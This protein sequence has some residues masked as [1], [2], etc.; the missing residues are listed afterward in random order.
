M[1]KDRLIVDA[2]KKSGV[3]RIAVVDD[4]FD[5]PP[6]PPASDLGEVL[7][8]FERPDAAE[9]F[10]LAGLAGSVLARAVSA[11][12]KGDEDDD[13]LH[14]CWEGLYSAFLKGF[15]VKF[16]PAGRFGII[17]GDNLA[18][19]RPLLKLLRTCG[20]GIRIDEIGSDGR[21]LDN[22][23]HD[24]HLIFADFILDGRI[25]PSD[26]ARDDG[27][28]GLGRRIAL[29]KVRDIVRKA[30]PGRAPSVVLMSSHENLR[31]EASRFREGIGEGD[32]GKVFNSRFCFIAK[33]QLQEGS[34][35]PVLVDS[36]AANDLL[37]VFASYEFGQGLQ[38]ALDRWLNGAAAAVD[39]L[40]SDIERLD[41]RDFAYLVR[42]R[43]AQ[44]GQG[45]LDYLEWF[46]GECLLDGVS[47][48]VDA[49]GTP[50]DA[51][52]MDAKAAERLQGVFAGPTGEV[53][54]LFHRVRIEDH[55]PGRR[56]EYRLGDIYERPIEGTK[57]TVAAVLTPDCDLIRRKNGKRAAKS[58]LTVRGK[59]SPLRDP[60]KEGS[61]SDF[62]QIGGESYNIAW[63]KKELVS[64]DP[65]GWPGLGAGEGGP[66]YL[67]T[68]RPLYAQQLQR[69]VLHDLGRVGVSVAP[70]IAM[71]ANV[72]VRLRAKGGKLIDVPIGGTMSGLCHVFPGR[73]GQDRTRVLFDRRYV[74][75]LMGALSGEKEALALSGQVF[76]QPAFET[77]VAELRGD[78]AFDA[79]VA[80]LCHDG[81]ELEMEVAHGFFVTTKDA[82]GSAQGK[83]AW[84]LLVIAG[85]R[86]DTE[87]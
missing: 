78:H 77:R 65:G 67:G 86:G 9:L 16:D 10:A 81:A 5:V 48:N 62:I 22:I 61:V 31:D 44:E 6:L 52:V 51:A 80:V 2:I 24:V 15:E 82:P 79:L 71:S 34:G 19:L 13:D 58:L 32:R 66:A 74:S 28:S 73:G 69:D 26:D 1:I 20:D 33:T 72:R 41:I 25:K 47:R 42:F 14:A 21:E 68:L 3:S 85:V 40:R 7:E 37:D 49:S 12:R 63:D 83:A 45:L 4:V 70:A 35:G 50:H 30:P 17:K 75:D 84:C 59:L 36:Q 8:F 38:E 27:V 55:R 46:F 43:L 54:K 53:A 23:G 56:G 39:A 87:L 76:D 11:I 18:N 57:R 60:D 29:D 64:Y